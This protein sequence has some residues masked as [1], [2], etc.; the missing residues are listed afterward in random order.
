MAL[1]IRIY[2]ESALEETAAAP[3]LAAPYLAS[4]NG[5]FHQYT[6]NVPGIEFRMAVGGKIPEEYFELC[7]TRSIYQP[8]WIDSRADFAM[9][10]EIGRR[11]QAALRQ[12]R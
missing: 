12:G 6:F 11:Y 1:I 5:G 2:A 9:N 3:Y 10:Q 7:P 4:K 8:L